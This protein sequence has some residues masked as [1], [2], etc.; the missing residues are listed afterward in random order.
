MQNSGLAV[1]LGLEIYHGKLTA[2]PVPQVDLSGQ[3]SNSF[4]E[5]FSIVF[6][7]MTTFVAFGPL[8]PSST[9]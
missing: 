3:S 8:R 9:S 1:L 4:I 2:N 5:N 6:Y 7:A